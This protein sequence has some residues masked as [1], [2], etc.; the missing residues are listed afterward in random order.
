[1]RS[2]RP[3]VT[4]PARPADQY[5]DKSRERIIEFSDPQSPDGCRGGLIAFRRL[6]DGTLLVNLYRL[7]DGITVTVTDDRSD[8]LA[9]VTTGIKVCPDCLDVPGKDGLGRTCKR[10]GGSGVMKQAEV[11]NA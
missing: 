10:C 5:S 4:N 8:V 11:R 6:N 3:R 1:M 9:R 7:D 2:I